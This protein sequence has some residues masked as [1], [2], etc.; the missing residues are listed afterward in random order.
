[1]KKSLLNTVKTN[2]VHTKTGIIGQRDERGRECSFLHEHEGI[3]VLEAVQDTLDNMSALV[4]LR[5]V[6]SW[7]EERCCLSIMVLFL[8]AFFFNQRGKKVLAQWLGCTHLCPSIMCINERGFVCREIEEGE[9][10][11]FTY[12]AWFQLASPVRLRID[13]SRRAK[14]RSPW[15]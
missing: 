7:A 12:W 15:R 13:V 11:W 10:G 2:N 8:I 5:A 6:L 1:M 3:K 14:P 9:G 4:R